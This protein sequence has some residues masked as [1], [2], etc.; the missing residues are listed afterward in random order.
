MVGDVEGGGVRDRLDRPDDDLLPRRAGLR[1][2]LR[3]H[4]RRRH[5]EQVVLRQDRVIG[6][7]QSP[8]DV[9]RLPVVAAPVLL[10]DIRAE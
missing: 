7:D 10:V 1:H 6:R 2:G 9:H 3:F 5:Q 8:G 4:R